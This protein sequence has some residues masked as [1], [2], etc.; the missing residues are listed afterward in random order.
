VIPDSSSKFGASS[1]FQTTESGKKQ[2]I[3]EKYFPQRLGGINNMKTFTN[4]SGRRGGKSKKNEPGGKDSAFPPGG[5]H[6][7]L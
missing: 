2:Q 5:E 1:K 3:T 4:I 6:K 7:Y